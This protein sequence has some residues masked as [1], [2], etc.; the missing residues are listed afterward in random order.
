MARP[1]F[2]VS[3]VV[4][5]IG[6]TLAPRYERPALPVPDRFAGA[7]GTLA[8]A[9]QGW[10]KMF[11]DPRLQALIALALA[12]NRDLR[13]A[14]LNIE[15]A[16]AQYRVQRAGLLPSVDANA[17]WTR[18][19][20]GALSSGLF[21]GSGSSSAA[22][23][24]AGATFPPSFYLVGVSAAYELDLFG[25]VRSLTA[26]ARE[27]YLATVEA[28]RATHLSLVAQIATQYLA[29]R[30]FAEQ[31]EI[32]VRTEV[33]TR[34]TYELTRQLFELGQ[35]SEVD[36]RATEAQ[37]QHSLGE[38]QRLRRQWQQAGN[39]LV[40]LV[41]QPLPANLPPP[42]RL[43][44][45][46]MIVDLAAGLPSQ[47]LLR[48]PDVLEAEHA[49]RAANANIGAMR[50]ALFPSIS[51]TGL[52]GT[53]STALDHLF[54][55]GTGF[56]LISSMITVPLFHGGANL[57]NLD[58]ANA[59]KRI[60]IARYEHAI[61]I[62]F[63]EVADALVAR[64]TYERELAAQAAQA[65]AQQVRFDLSLQRYRAGV[66]S[67]LEVLSAQNDLY[68]AQQALIALRADRLTN[69]ADLYRALGGGW[70]ES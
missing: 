63:R 70:L 51:L 44:A 37:W 16:Q 64:E 61:Q 12:N 52:A 36:L 53:V 50:A 6:C 41:G 7:G 67:Y 40:V 55:D 5:L 58:A 56:G 57:A 33:T 17:S 11:G 42:Q 9:D 24:A 62:A 59:Q 39:A 32:A 34:Q 48:R 66:A 65:A 29:E 20:G 27:S 2:T 49:L 19:G 22:G 26:Q 3:L 10:R 18:L 4:S 60:Q 38:V 69:L 15:L 45:Q 68:A 21:T 47:V 25:R 35:R 8:A 30:S 43:S 31:Y 1:L 46:R 23:A 13:V 54:Q 28:H 14:A